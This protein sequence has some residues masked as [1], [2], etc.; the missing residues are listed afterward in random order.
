MMN[1]DFFDTI[2]KLDFILL[3]LIGGLF[4]AIMNLSGAT[5]VFFV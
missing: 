1:L 5:S 3:A 2:L 4:L